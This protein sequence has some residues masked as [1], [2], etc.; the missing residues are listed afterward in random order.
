MQVIPFTDLKI[1]NGHRALHVMTRTVYRT[2]ARCR[3]SSSYLV[4]ALHSIVIYTGPFLIQVVKYMSY[5]I[6]WD[7]YLVRL[8]TIPS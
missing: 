8:S 1:T 3:K 2:R 6:L 5:D 7:A 4:R